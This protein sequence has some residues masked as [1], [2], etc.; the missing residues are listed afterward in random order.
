MAAPYS[1]N[2][3]IDSFFQSN[4]TTATRRQCDDF[5]FAH[6]TPVTPIQIQGMFSYTALVGTDK[7]KSFSFES[8]V[9]ASMLTS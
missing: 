2:A 3:A 8:L 4:P 7:V 9:P 6:G 1:L 5:A